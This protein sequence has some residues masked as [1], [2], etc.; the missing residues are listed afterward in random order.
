MIPPMTQNF[1]FATINV[2]NSNPSDRGDINRENTNNRN[3]STERLSD[4]SSYRIFDDNSKVTDKRNISIQNKSD[5]DNLQ[6]AQNVNDV[7]CLNI[8]RDIYVDVIDKKD[9]SD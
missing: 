2:Q 8:C 4:N 5:S 3:F 6:N 9:N 7:Q 1:F